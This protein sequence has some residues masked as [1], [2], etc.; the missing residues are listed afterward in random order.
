MCGCGLER[1]QL[2]P[3]SKRPVDSDRDSDDGCPPTFAELLQSCAGFLA[4]RDAFADLFAHFLLS[5]GG[6]NR[7]RVRG[8]TGQGIYERSPRLISPDGRFAD[9]QPTGQPS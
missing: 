5:G 1:R 6:G 4:A 7:T 2:A 9:D 3:G 8:R